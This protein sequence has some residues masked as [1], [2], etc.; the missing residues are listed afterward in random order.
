MRGAGV[1]VVVVVVGGGGG[2]GV[3]GNKKRV[4][5]PASI[6]RAVNEMNEP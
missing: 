2:G 4:H 1:V 6:A 3:G 5:V